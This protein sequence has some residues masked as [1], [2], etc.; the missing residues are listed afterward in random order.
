MMEMH[1]K[2]VAFVDVNLVPMDNERILGN[3]TVIVDQDKI[4]MIGEAAKVRVPSNALRIDARGKYLMPG[5][6]DMHTHTWGEADFFLFI[7][8]GVTTIRN[9]WGSSRQLAWRKRIAN[10]SLLGPTIYTA[11]PLIDGK[12]PI[13]NGSKVVE[14]REQAE[15]EVAREKKWAMTSSKYTIGYHWKPS[16]RL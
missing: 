13:W 12:P 15:E 16:K 8:N 7:A 3:Q 11:G 10:G 1:E 6:A 14:T 9:M 5:L 4:T 2:P